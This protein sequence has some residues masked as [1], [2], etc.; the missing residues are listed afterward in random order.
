MGRPV[1]HGPCSVLRLV[2]SGRVSAPAV[3]DVRLW[4]HTLELPGGVV[5][6][7]WFDLRRHVQRLPWPEVRGQ[8]CLDVGTYDGF[9]AFEME[10]R[11]AREVIALDI[12]D[13]EDW[14]W[15]AAARAL[16][17]E[18]LA[19]LAGE[20]GAG[21]AAAAQALG[22]RVQRVQLSAYHL[23][24]EA[25]GTFD[26]VLCGSLMLHLRD[27]VRA[28]EAIRSVCGG[29]FLSIEE[30]SLTLG[31][32]FPRRAM[33]EMRFDE[34]LCQWWVANPAGHRRMAEIA[35]FEVVR[36][37]RPY[38]EPFGTGHPSFRGDQSEPRG[39]LRARR[40]GSLLAGAGV[41]HAALLARPR[42]QAPPVRL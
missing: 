1:P 4:Y 38:R 33:A 25:L 28:L 18:A 17:G 14:D 15:P 2:P 11:G 39:R 24:P 5:T 3:D 9:Y 20:K 27:P 40:D 31:L 42:L 8:R 12:S 23:N 29:W 16:G 7:G 21:F 22:S 32:S 35:G 10:R 19:R 6:P 26:V 36:T 41:P 37:L 34:E 13:H 30:V